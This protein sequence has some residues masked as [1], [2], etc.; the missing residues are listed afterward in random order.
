[1]KRFGAFPA[2]LLISDTVLRWDK[3]ESAVEEHCAS[4]APSAVAGGRGP[5][6]APS[7][8]PAVVMLEPSAAVA[9]QR[10]LD[11]IDALAAASPDGPSI[12]ALVSTARAALT[13]SCR[14][15][16]SCRAAS[17]T[18]R[19]P[20]LSDGPR[21]CLSE[22]PTCSAHAGACPVYRRIIWKRLLGAALRGE[23]F[24]ATRRCQPS[25]QPGISER[26]TATHAWRASG[27]AQR[28]PSIRRRAIA[29]FRDTP[30]H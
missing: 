16:A 25:P 1:M 4:I 17:L 18:A 7:A 9:L 11:G 6:S 23:E 29:L 22:P 28:R 10:A 20:V 30:R 24:G 15:G 5:R 8:D 13:V 3:L 19:R 21:A 12:R 26:A 2:A 27:R 14:A